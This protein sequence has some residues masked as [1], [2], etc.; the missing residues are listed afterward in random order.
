MWS[1]YAPTVPSP[2]WYATGSS[3]AA[4]VSPRGT[5]HDAEPSEPVGVGVAPPEMLC[6][7][8]GH[9]VAVGAD[10][11]SEPPHGG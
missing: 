7:G 6:A 3:T 8:D 11:P 9:P 1:R 4:T 2:S 10:L 5:V